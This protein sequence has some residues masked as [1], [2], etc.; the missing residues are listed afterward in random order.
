MLEAGTKRNGAKTEFLESNFSSSV[1]F[2]P[3]ILT[4]RTPVPPLMAL[5]ICYL[6]SSHPAH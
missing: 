2:T 6:P 1:P 5:V 4:S 3:K